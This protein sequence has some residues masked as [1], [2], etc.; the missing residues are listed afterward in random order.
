MDFKATK[1]P[2][3]KKESEILERYRRQLE[4]YAHVIEERYGLS[5]SRLNL[6]YTGEEDGSPMVSFKKEVKHIDKTIAEVENVVHN[7]EAGH[8]NPL[9]TRPKTCVDCDLRHYCNRY[10]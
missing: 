3:L 8:F 10:A 1:K 5:V 6:Y 7:I 2:D 9:A 4:I